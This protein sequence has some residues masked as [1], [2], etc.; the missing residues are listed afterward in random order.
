MT[1]FTYSRIPAFN[2]NTSP[3]SVAKSATGSVY[4]IGDTGFTT[5]LNLTLVATNTVTITLISDVNGMFPDFT[6]VDRTSVVFK[7][8]AEKM[9]LTTTTPVPGPTGPASTVPGPAG[10][11]TTDASL[12]T[13]GTVADARLPTR[14]SDASLSA[15]YLKLGHTDYLTPTAP[16]IELATSAGSGRLFHYLSGAGSTSEIGGYGVDNDNSQGTVYSLKAKNNIGIGVNLETTSGSDSIGILGAVLATGKAMELRKGSQNGGVLVSL[17]ADYGGTGTLFQWGLP[18]ASVAATLTVTGSTVTATGHGMVAGQRLT[19][20]AITGTTGITNGTTYYVAGTVTANTFQVAASLGG[21]A[22]T[23]GGVNGTANYVA[24]DNLN[25]YIDAVDGSL[26]LQSGNTNP[27]KIR[28]SVVSGGTQ[29]AH[30]VYSGTPGLWFPNAVASSSNSFKFQQ[31]NAAAI[32]SETMTTLIE[33][34]NTNAIALYGGTPVSQAAS[35]TTPAA[36]SF[37]L[38][39]Y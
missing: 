6:L 30:Y 32:G 14:L 36:P 39:I 4:D 38:F 10:P 37:N 5:P 8:G 33:L 21:A 28:A 24:A 2:P 3:V 12:L 31:G 7:S 19:F 35:I 27:S 9:V 13:A 20:S 16:M 25:G 1:V 23:F 11:A 26:V 34:K 18:G 17:R 15:T 29:E 22:I